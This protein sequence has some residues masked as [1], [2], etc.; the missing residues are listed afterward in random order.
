MEPGLSQNDLTSV[1]RDNTDYYFDIWRRVVWQKFTD[2]PVEI[3]AFFFR[4]HGD[5]TFFRNVGECL[6][7]ET[8]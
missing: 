5:S 1:H 4:I 8:A 6:S 7:E 2:V 3:T